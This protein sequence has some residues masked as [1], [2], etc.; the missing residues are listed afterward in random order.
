MST[1]RPFPPHAS[2]A[3]LPL[4]ALP[5]RAPPLGTPSPSGL[6]LN[7]VK[8]SGAL[9]APGTISINNTFSKGTYK[10]NLPPGATA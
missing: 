1:I 2:L 6:D 7:G 10:D 4:P 5:Y 3:A 9:K 8:P